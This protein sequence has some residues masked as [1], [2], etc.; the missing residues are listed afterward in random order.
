MPRNLPRQVS[1]SR[2]IWID[3]QHGLTGDRAVRAGRPRLRE[4]DQRIRARRD[5]HGD[6]PLVLPAASERKRFQMDVGEPPLL[7]GLLRPVGRFL[8]VRRAGQA[9]TVDIGEV[10]LGLH[11]LR[12]LQPFFFDSVDGIEVDSFRIGPISGERKADGDRQRGDE[13][14]SACLLHRHEPPELDCSSCRGHRAT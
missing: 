10:A 11:H 4:T 6:E 7:H 9:G 12:A 2:S 5:R 13:K 8:D 1:K 3:R 14:C